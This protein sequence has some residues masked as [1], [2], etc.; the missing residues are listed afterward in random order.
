MSNGKAVIIILLVGVIKRIL[1]NKLTF[2][3]EPSTRS[4][5][6]IN[7]ELVLSNYAA[8]VGLKNGIDV[9]TSKFAKS[10]EIASL[11]TDI[12]KLDIDDL[13]KVQSSLRNLKR[14][15]DKWD[16]GKVEITSFHLGKLNR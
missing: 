14:T 1:S 8:N 16:T 6:K 13:E 15:V 2:F 11:K 3:G 4:K 5:S 7:I 9:D 10:V 12:D